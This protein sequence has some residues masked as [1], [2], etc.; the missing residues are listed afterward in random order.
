MRRRPKTSSIS[1]VCLPPRHSSL[2]TR[3]QRSNCPQP[4]SSPQTEAERRLYE[5]P[6]HLKIA[7]AVRSDDQVSEAWLTG[8]QEVE[9]PIEYLRLPPLLLLL[10]L[11]A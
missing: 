11:C 4:P 7:E 2:G 10:D 1:E 5:T 6:E 9:L 8:I 3:R